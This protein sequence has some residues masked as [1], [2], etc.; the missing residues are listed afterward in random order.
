MEPCDRPTSPPVLFTVTV[1]PLSDPLPVTDT[2]CALSTFNAPPVVSVPELESDGV[3]ILNGALLPA[4][5]VVLP[6]MLTLAPA[7]VAL[8]VTVPDEPGLKL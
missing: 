6:A 2:D 1:D 3:L 4:V 7:E 5:T 8:K